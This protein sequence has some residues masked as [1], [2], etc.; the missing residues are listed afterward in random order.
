MKLPYLKHKSWPRD[1]QKIEEKLIQ[2][3]ASDHLD[4]H[5]CQEMFDAVEHKDIKR[6]RAALEAL[7]MNCFEG[8]EDGKDA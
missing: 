8:S 5:C 1:G 2:G 3:S 4:H 7:V 6:Y